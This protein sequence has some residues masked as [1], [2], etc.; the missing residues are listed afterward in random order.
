MDVITQARELGA[1]SGAAVVG[2]C[3]AVWT[4]YKSIRGD[5][6]DAKQQAVVDGTTNAILASL[7]STLEDALRE[8][9]VERERADRLGQQL[10]ELGRSV[11]ALEASLA[12]ALERRQEL[13]ER[14]EHLNETVEELVQENRNK[15]RSIDELVKLNR[16]LLINIGVK[17]PIEGELS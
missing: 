9:K 14:V 16:Q 8:S 5:I 13:E 10:T 15:D 17:S 4:F 12:H 2:A 7:R 1:A 11:G 6:R 3:W